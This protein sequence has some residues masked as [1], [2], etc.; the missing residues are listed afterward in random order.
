MAVALLLAL[1]L[2]AALVDAHSSTAAMR[3]SPRRP[4]SLELTRAQLK[5][6]TTGEYELLPGKRP[7]TRDAFFLDALG[8]EPGAPFELDYD[9]WREVVRCGMFRNLTAKVEPAGAG[10]EVTLRISGMEMP[11]ITFAPEVCNPNPKP[12]ATGQPHTEHLL[13]HLTCRVLNAVAQVTVGASV[14]RP[15][16]SGGVSLVDK[17]FRG[18]GERVELLVSKREGT[19]DGVGRLLPNLRLLW[20]SSRVGRDS[21]MSI[22]E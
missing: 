21:D 11:S 14:E 13:S 4:V 12:C 5:N 2:V 20:Q 10:D 17:N 7:R 18:G 8:L 3:L 19:E 6:A 9:K 15:E 1:L 16:M 22:G